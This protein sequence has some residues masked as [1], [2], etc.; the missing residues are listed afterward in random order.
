MENTWSKTIAGHSGVLLS[1]PLLVFLHKHFQFQRICQLNYRQRDGSTPALFKKA[2]HV[3]H[4]Q[5][6]S[7]G[8][9]RQKQR[10]LIHFR[11]P[12]FKMGN[13]DYN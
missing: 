11:M 10:W 7:K 2:K 1:I 3:F 4:C 6:V 9:K 12:S 8:A 13:R 5:L